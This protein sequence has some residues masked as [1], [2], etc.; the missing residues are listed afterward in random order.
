MGKALKECREGEVNGTISTRGERSEVYTDSISSWGTG[1]LDFGQPA[2]DGYVGPC[3]LLLPMVIFEVT[4]Q[5]IRYIPQPRLFT[6]RDD[7]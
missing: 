3:S 1:V 5:R 4:R 6:E 7:H 2:N